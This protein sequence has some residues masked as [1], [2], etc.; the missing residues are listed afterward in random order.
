[1]R[2]RTGRRR[3]DQEESD[4]TPFFRDA[5]GHMHGFISRIQDSRPTVPFGRVDGAPIVH[6]MC[7]R[8]PIRPCPRN[9]WRKECTNCVS[10]ARS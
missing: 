8:T 9:A 10:C 1:V 4:G 5:S 2:A 3:E 6:E 7:L